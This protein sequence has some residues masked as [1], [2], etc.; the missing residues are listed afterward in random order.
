MTQGRYWTSGNYTEEIRINKKV[1]EEVWELY[2]HSSAFKGWYLSQE[3]NRN[4]G[5][6]ID[7][8]AELGGYCKTGFGGKTGV[9][10]T[11]YRRGEKHFTIHPANRK[12]NLNKP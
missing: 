6:I 10:F 2:G 3:S 7:L 9:D 5:A 8:Y 4:A 11:L 12:N 1:I